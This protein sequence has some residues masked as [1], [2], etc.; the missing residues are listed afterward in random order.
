MN[1]NGYNNFRTGVLTI[2]TAGTELPL[3]GVTHAAGTLT[4]VVGSDSVTGSGT[5]FITAHVGE[6]MLT[7]GG[8]LYKIV[9]FTSTTVI[10]IS[11]IVATGDGESGVAYKIYEILQNT[12]RIHVS[13]PSV[14]TGDVYIG[15]RGSISATTG[16]CIPKGTSEELRVSMHPPSNLP[17]GVNNDIWADAGNSA[18]KISY[19]ILF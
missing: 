4:T 9:G 15:L 17:D 3:L 13:A 18:D 19:A 2:A 5:T 1:E 7:A 6:Y 16:F 12:G 8:K 14:N 10:K 11:P